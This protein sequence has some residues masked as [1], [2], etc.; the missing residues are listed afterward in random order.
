MT[1]RRDIDETALRKSLLA[2]R[3]EVVALNEGHA[4]DSDT[5]EV[6]SAMGRLSRMDA[7]QQQAI[8]AEAAR[9]RDLEL[10]R[11]DAALKRMDEDEYGY[12]VTCGDEI[13]KKRLEFDPT[14]TT[15]IKCAR[16]GERNH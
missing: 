6:D 11:I 1:D 16:E 14:A 7:L 2:L 12:C 13:G 10:H 5:V 9:R 3:A 8:A 15:C 4:H